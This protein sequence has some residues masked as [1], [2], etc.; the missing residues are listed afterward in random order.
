MR[1]VDVN[2]GRGAIDWQQVRSA[3]YEFA[4]IKATEGRTWD[5]S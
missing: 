4:F 1:G 5:D 3:G 2:D